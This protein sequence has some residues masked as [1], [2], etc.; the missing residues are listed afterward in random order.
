MITVAT[1]L[2][3]LLNY[4]TTTTNNNNDNSNTDNML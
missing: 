2:T 1:R 4:D 3:I